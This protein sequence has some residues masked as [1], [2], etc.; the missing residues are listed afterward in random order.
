MSC[1]W[2]DVAVVQYDDSV[3]WDLG[4]IAKPLWSTTGSS[5][6][7]TIDIDPST[8]RLQITSNAYPAMGSYVNKVGRSSGW[9]WGPVSRTCTDFP[10]SHYEPIMPGDTVM[11]CQT[12]VDATA[13]GGDS[14]SPAFIY[15]PQDK[16]AIAGIV[17]G[18][19]PNG[20]GGWRFVFSP[21]DQ[22][23][24]DI[25]SFSSN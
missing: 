8:P 15:T 18:Q 20:S 19:F 3:A 2:S 23:R 17:W 22:I 21:L 16:A 5:T 25:I 24:N 9:T 12:E 4:Y 13:I 7:Y 14:G 10:W 1:R 11:L 6:D